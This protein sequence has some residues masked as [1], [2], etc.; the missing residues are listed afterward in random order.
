M[1]VESG[2]THGFDD[3]VEGHQV[4]AVSVQGEPR[5]TH[6]GGRCD[7]V[8]FDARHLHETTDGITGQAEVVFHGNFC[9]V[10]NLSWGAAK[11]STEPGG[12]HRTRGPNFTLTT[13]FSARN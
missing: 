11:N 4:R 6:G 12:G 2:L 5:G 8:A 9:G 3:L 10:L 13:R 7:C 1:H